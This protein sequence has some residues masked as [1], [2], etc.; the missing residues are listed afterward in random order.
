MSNHCSECHA[1]D[2]DPH[3]PGCS[4]Y[5]P[6][7]QQDLSERDDRISELER[8]VEDLEQRLEAVEALVVP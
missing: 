4:S 5:R 6:P 8:K 2:D 3:N 7:T 1:H